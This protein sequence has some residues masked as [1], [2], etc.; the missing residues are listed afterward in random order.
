MSD[1]APRSSFPLSPKQIVAIVLA[2][3]A[4][5]FVL[6]NRDDA[7]I[8][9]LWSTLTMPVW[10]AFGGLLIVGVLIGLLLAN[11]RTRRR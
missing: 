7:S 6:Q 11:R 10:V 3:L 4:V 1:P 9:L 2:A 8:N 5:I